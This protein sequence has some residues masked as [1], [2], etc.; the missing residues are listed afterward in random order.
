M[1]W[2][3]PKI[4]IPMVLLVACRQAPPAGSAPWSGEA[5]PPD[6]SVAARPA[7]PVVLIQVDGLPADWLER[8][9]AEGR[10]LPDQA[11]A[12]PDRRRQGAWVRLAEGVRAAALRPVEPT[13]TAVNL[14]SMLSGAWPR[15]HG[16]LANTYLRG[17]RRVSGFVQPSAR[18]LLWQTAL[19]HGRRVL[20]WV[21]LGTRCGAPVHPRHRALC[22]PEKRGLTAGPRP[23]WVPLDGPAGQESATVELE[24]GALAT[25][26]RRLRLGLA[27]EGNR[28][29]LSL[30]PGARVSRGSGPVLAPGDTVAIQWPGSPRPELNRA[31]D[32]PPD[33][34]T[35]LTLVTVDAPGRRV[36]LHHGGT[37]IA[38]AQP[39]SF[40]RAL[41]AAGVFRPVPADDEGLARGRIDEHRFVDGV[42]AEL[43]A[44]V[45]FG[46][47]FLAPADFDLAIVYVAAVDALGHSLLADDR[48]PDLAR[49]EARR[50][51]AALEDGLRRVDLRLAELLDAL[52][53]GRTRVIVASDHGMVPVVTDVSLLAAVR[54]VAP[55]ARVTTSGAS[56]YVYLPPGADVDAVV[57]HLGSLAVARRPVFAGGRIA[58]A[59]DL[60]GLGLPATA[61]DLLVQAG[62]GFTLS[63]R[64]KQRLVAWPKAMGQHGHVAEV[65]DMA[66]VLLAAGPGVREG[67]RGPAR[68]PEVAALV[69][70]AAGLTPP[71]GAAALPEPWFSPR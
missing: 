7:P 36:L 41:E 39:A 22:Y 24:A 16:I 34:E 43:D 64:R 56:G 69:A 55:A 59:A 48:R 25:G 37:V 5:P 50:F 63:S 20:T 10:F 28:V 12:P 3:A 33:R 68:M 67:R 29:R 13:L 58:R 35:R 54:A 70:Q 19:R 65:A 11:P 62:P 42:L 45:A 23:T 38:R 14:A 71:P 66:G 4:L 18:E 32:P 1:S 40:R 49:A 2:L 6:A 51:R 9:L 52:D 46:R 31:T 8:W 60:P 47:R 17:G 21:A 57:R 27:R 44:V 30:P 61:A 26:E 53:L 15:E